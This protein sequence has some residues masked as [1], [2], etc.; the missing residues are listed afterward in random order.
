MFTYLS[1]KGK[2]KTKKRKDRKELV[3]KEDRRG[4]HERKIRGKF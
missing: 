3:G 1:I 2:E 4:Y